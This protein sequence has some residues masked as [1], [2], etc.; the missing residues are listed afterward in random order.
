M[1]SREVTYSWPTRLIHIGLAAF[2]IAAY[3][4]AEGAEDGGDSFGFLLHAYLG[5]SVATF[6]LLRLIR[7]F[8]G[9]EQM[10]FSSWSPFSARQWH[11]ARDDLRV[12]FRLR[13][14][15]RQL[16][17][18]FAGLV[19][20]FGF[21]IFTWMATTGVMIFLIGGESETELFEILEELH[22]VGENLVPLYLILHVG[23]VLLHTFLGAHIWRRM[24]SFSRTRD[25]YQSK[26][27]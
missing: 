27:W 26:P 20:S 17:E 8:I 11:M 15:E 9:P 13:V 14:P 10:R 19:Q 3:F 6:V 24:F 1:N 18:G 5:L 25:S 7:G 12:M 16:H 4:T 2:G 23:G 21:L 22:E